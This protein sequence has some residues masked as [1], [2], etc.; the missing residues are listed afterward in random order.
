MN[1]YKIAVD[2]LN[3]NIREANAVKDCERCGGELSSKT[4]GDE[5]HDVCSDCGHSEA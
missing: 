5:T 1:L 4:V 3:D 2:Q